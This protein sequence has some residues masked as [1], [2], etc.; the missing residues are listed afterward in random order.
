[1]DRGGR[2]QGVMGLTGPYGGLVERV[3]VRM[4]MSNV[5]RTRGDFRM[6]REPLPLPLTELSLAYT[7]CMYVCMY[8]YIHSFMTL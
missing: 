8:I 4:R 7:L 1:M 6:H 5:D 2:K 3:R